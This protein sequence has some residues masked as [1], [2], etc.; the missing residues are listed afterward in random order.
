MKK[1]I[2]GLLIIV[3]AF[4]SCTD[5]EEIEI[6]Y[7]TNMSITASHIFDDFSTVLGDE[8]EMQGTNYGEWDLNLHAFIYDI[9]GNLVQSNEAQYSSL[10]N[11]LV[12]DLDLLPGKYSVIAIAEFTGIVQ[13]QNYKFW[14][15]SNAENLNDLNIVESST[16]CNS[17]FETLGIT[18][19]EF[20][21]GEH[22]E[23]IT[24]DNFHF[25]GEK[26]GIDF[27][28][29][30]EAAINNL[31]IRN[32]TFTDNDADRTPESGGI[33]AIHMNADNNGKYNNITVENCIIER[34]YQG[35]YLQ[36]V[37]GATIN[38]CK[39]TD[40]EHN[41][42]AI[43]SSTENFSGKICIED[44]EMTDIHD[45]AIRFGKGENAEIHILHNTIN[46][47]GDGESL[48]LSEILQNSEYEQIGNTY[49]G[50]PITDKE[51]ESAILISVT[52]PE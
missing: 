41:A 37:N 11:A 52:K 13:G 44:N 32:C 5:Q 3:G 20:E 15:I 27:G 34:C 18:S 26:S 31:T 19:K 47:S 40:T 33:A 14:N 12:F 28:Y 36:C 22:V 46:N 16:I 38:D 21:I 4:V 8:F 35:I 48:V 9:N 6:A 50:R 45:R 24:I 2:A 7:Q 51:L 29:Y 43:Q 39:F 25:N 17:P 1:I 30:E 10:E 23:N 49:D 42:V